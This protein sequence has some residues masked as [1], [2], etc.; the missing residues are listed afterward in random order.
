MDRRR[1]EII[2][3]LQGTLSVVAEG[4]GECRSIPGDTGGRCG[5]AGRISFRRWE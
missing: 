2:V 3:Q 1:G 5:G 4:L